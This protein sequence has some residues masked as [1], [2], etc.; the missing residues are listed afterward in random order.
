LR[1][2]AHLRKIGKWAPLPQENSQRSYIMDE[3]I[4]K[5]AHPHGKATVE[6][7]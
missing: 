5:W 7:T 4:M 6:L 3:N 1:E 2:V